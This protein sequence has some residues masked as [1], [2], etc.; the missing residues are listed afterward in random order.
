MSVL[1]DATPWN[2]EVLWLKNGRRHRKD[3]GHDFAGAEMLERKLLVAGRKDVTLRCKNYGF[4]PPQKYQPR[5]VIVRRGRKRVRGINRPM[6]GLNQRG[7][8]WCPYCR[9]M[10]RFK[11]VSGFRVDGI[12]V[13]EKRHVCPVCRIN[14]SDHHVKKHNPMAVRIEWDLRGR[15]GKKKGRRR[16]R[17]GVAD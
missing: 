17:R 7:I 9:K 16:R 12:K 10:R 13:E 11:T 4:P 2:W 5:E 6:K 8:F 14:V 1:A 15:S 3:F